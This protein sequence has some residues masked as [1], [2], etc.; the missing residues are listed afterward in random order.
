MAPIAGKTKLQPDKLLSFRPVGRVI[1]ESGIAA[2]FAL[3]RKA[4]GKKVTSSIMER[5]CK[6]SGTHLLKFVNPRVDSHQATLRVNCS[7]NKFHNPILPSGNAADI[8]VAKLIFRP[9]EIFGYPPR[10]VADHIIDPNELS[11]KVCVAFEAVFG[12]D[13]LQAIEKSLR[14]PAPV[15][16]KLEAKEF[17]II[18]IPSPEGGDLQVTP[19][20][21]AASYLGMQEVAA[22][23]RKKREA[24]EPT[25]PRGKW[26]RQKISDKAQNISGAISKLRLRFRATMPSVMLKHEAAIWQ[27]VHGGQFPRWYDRNIMQ[28]VL[29]YAQ[30][31]ERAQVFSNSEIRAGL[32]ARADRLISDSIAFATEVME[33]AH[34][35]ATGQGI[36]PES[37]MAPRSARTLLLSL[38]RQGTDDFDRARW[39]MNAPHFGQR[40]QRHR[41][42]K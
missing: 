8:P 33:E 25:L 30:A 26:N 23:Y 32:N 11:K 5:I 6:Q 21:P 29:D 24:T 18:F 9:L 27:F 34:F 15:I 37:L 16:Q 19:L 13:V 28:I 36:S 1:D 3:M 12:R 41:S 31:L 22:P 2:E 17:P 35:L 38:F 4:C 14:E 7:N 42:K 20:A 10:S 39:A 40:V